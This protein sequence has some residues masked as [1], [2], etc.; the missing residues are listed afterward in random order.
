MVASDGTNTAST[1]TLSPDA[2]GAS[3]GSFSL[4]NLITP[5]TFTLAAT[6]DG[7]LTTNVTVRLGP[8]ESA[9]QQIVLRPSTG[10][11]GGTVSSSGPGAGPLGGVTVTVAGPDFTRTT[12]SLTTDPIGSWQVTD[13][14][15]PG[16]YTVTFT[17]AGFGTQALGVDL[18]SAIPESLALSATLA[19]ATSNITGR[20]VEA[21]N[22]A[23]IVGATVTL[24]GQG[25][26]RTAL[27]ANQPVGAYG[28][29]NL[30]PGA[31]TITFQRT[32]SADL[33][34]AITLQPGDNPQPDA[35]LEQPAG[36]SGQVRV[37]GVPFAGAIVRMYLV[38]T[39]GP[40]Y[41]FTPPTAEVSTDGNGNYAR[42]RRAARQLPRR[43][44]HQRPDPAAL[45]ADLGE[46]GPCDRAH[47]L[48][49][50]HRATHNTVANEHTGTDHHE[51]PI[52]HNRVDHPGATQQRTSDPMTRSSEQ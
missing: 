42:R 8:G 12:T 3:A 46:P 1:L 24:T 28:F 39:G 2:S 48:R 38:Q 18:S 25:T 15:L 27:T 19:P 45:T 21:S 14:P 10:R 50:L 51:C 23:G 26:T 32:G 29:A 43:R 31:Y 7:Y 35:A 17:A 9:D 36:I 20:V 47:R 5:G 41:P 11:V 34:L 40:A 30:P 4:I 44:V 33:T 16:T 49:H 6:A 22:G 52:H 37:N 13:V